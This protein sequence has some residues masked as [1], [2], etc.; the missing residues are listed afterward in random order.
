[1]E[2]HDDM[3][4]VDVSSARKERSTQRPAQV[5]TTTLNASSGQ[6]RNNVQEGQGRVPR[7][8]LAEITNTAS[9]RT[10]AKREK[11]G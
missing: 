1:M 2:D 8:V 11:R 4:G 7:A 6:A 5:D 9:P 10:V 3:N